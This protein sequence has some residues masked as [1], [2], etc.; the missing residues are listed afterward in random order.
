MGWEPQPVR[1]RLNQVINWSL[2]NNR[3]LMSWA[4]SIHQWSNI[5]RV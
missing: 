2:E 1:D 5:S 3:W 4:K